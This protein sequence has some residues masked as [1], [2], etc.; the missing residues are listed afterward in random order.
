MK[1]IDTHG[2]FDEAMGSSSPEVQA[3]ARK[4][5]EFIIE[6]YPEVVEVPWLKQKIVGYG[7][8]PK[9]MS[10]HFCYLAAQ[11]S[12]VNLGFYYGVDLPDPDTLLEGTG[13]KL[14]HVKVKHIE[15]AGHASIRELIQLSI[16]ER[17]TALDIA[18]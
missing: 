5:R 2:T 13:K 3:I 18:D 8:G 14:R 12:R 7:V 11:S 9:K 17:K 10:E 16:Q 6:I 4:L 1:T 15:Q